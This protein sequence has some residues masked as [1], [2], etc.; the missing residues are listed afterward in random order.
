MDPDLFSPKRVDNIFKSIVPR[1]FCRRFRQMRW[2]PFDPLINSK[3]SLFAP[4]RLRPYQKQL[5]KTSEGRRS[6]EGAIGLWQAPFRPAVTSHPRT[7]IKQTETWVGGCAICQLVIGQCDPQKGREIKHP[8][9]SQS[10]M[11]T[12]LPTDPPGVVDYHD[13]MT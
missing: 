11:Y 8:K 5:G 4:R 9:R 13:G 12:F 7:V 2:V 6:K 1:K 3:I 10:Q